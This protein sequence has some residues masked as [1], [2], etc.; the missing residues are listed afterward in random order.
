MRYLLLIF[1]S[2][3]ICTLTAQSVDGFWS[4]IRQR[5]E[6]KD[7]FRISGQASAQFDYN[8]ISGINQ[9]RPGF[10]A[11]LQAGLGI[12]MMGIQIPVSVA[13]AR[14]GTVYNYQLPSYAFIGISP[15]YKWITL[16]AG[17]RS[18]SFSP[19]I[20]N[21]L[22]YRGGG[23]ELSPGKWRISA[24][25]GILRRASVVDAG[26]IQRLESPYR[27]I[28]SGLQLGYQSEKTNISLNIFSAR[29]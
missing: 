15:S 3:F 26:S 7:I 5:I 1:S 18:M 2:L 23:I 10:N 24:M 13:M 21:G 28:G 6:A 25:R 4:T 20:L 17:D 9:R 19:Y 14:G 16:H 29:D 8:S 12:D 22:S 11:R 27:R